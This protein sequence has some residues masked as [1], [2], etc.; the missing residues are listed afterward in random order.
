MK[1]LREVAP[2][3][4]YLVQTKMDRSVLVS[5]DDTESI[6]CT[7]NNDLEVTKGTFRQLGI[8]MS[9]GKSVMDTVSFL[10]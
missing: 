8:N 4:Q 6:V 1:F 9:L 10:S 2:M 5:A 3:Q 7:I